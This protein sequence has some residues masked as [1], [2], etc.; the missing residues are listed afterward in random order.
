NFK[1]NEIG[2]LSRH[3]L[4]RDLRSP[5]TNE[6]C[7]PYSNKK[8]NH[9]QI[10]FYLISCPSYTYE[11]GSWLSFSLMTQTLTVLLFTFTGVVQMII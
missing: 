11:I 10:L 3:L 2:N 7:I 9:L 5:G 6:R 1:S 8:T 4:L